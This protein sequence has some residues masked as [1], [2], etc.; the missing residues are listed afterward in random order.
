MNRLARPAR[1]PR[2]AD[3]DQ[4]DQTARTGR[5]KR[6]DQSRKAPDHVDQAGGRTL[7]RA[8]VTAP[9][10]EINAAAVAAY[11]A[12]LQEGKPMS[13]RKLAAAFGRTSRRWARARMAEAR[14]G[15]DEG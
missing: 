3:Q 4:P 7:G 8:A 11:R 15:S 10:G 14:Q 1:P 6:A 13:E 12:S 2:Y 5:T 9:A